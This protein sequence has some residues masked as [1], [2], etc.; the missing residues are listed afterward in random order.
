MKMRSL[1]Q[2]FLDAGTTNKEEMK[3]GRRA[4][5]GAHGHTRA[6]SPLH[7]RIIVII[8][9]ILEALQY[10]D[11]FKPFSRYAMSFDGHNN[12]KH[13]ASN[14]FSSYDATITLHPA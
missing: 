8:V 5:G 7:A 12:N 11:S 4:R 3:F 9:Y 10:L 14:I 6:L 1:R 13:K 2:T